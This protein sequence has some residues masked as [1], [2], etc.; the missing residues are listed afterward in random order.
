MSGNNLLW[1]IQPMLILTSLAVF[2]VILHALLVYAY[3]LSDNGWRRADYLWLV[4]AVLSLLGMSAEARHQWI[5][6]RKPISEQLHLGSVDYL[7]DSFLV[8][9]IFPCHVEFGRTDPAGGD[10]AGTAEQYEGFCPVW[11]APCV[12][13]LF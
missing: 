13:E 5:E 4:G 9:R 7:R 3:P 12:Q 10:Q 1:L 11:M 2:V 8:L 6:L